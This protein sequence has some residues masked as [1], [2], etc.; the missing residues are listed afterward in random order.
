MNTKWKIS[1]REKS[2]NLPP[3]FRS[4][5]VILI[6]NNNNNKTKRKVLLKGRRTSKEYILIYFSRKRWEKSSIITASASPFLFK[7]V[8][9]QQRDSV[10]SNVFFHANYRQPEGLIE[11]TRWKEASVVHFWE[12]RSTVCLW[13][14]L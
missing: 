10:A 13:I 9:V 6:F 3:L 14:G 8:R 7:I 12:S 1:P 11:A 2:L 4:I 5:H